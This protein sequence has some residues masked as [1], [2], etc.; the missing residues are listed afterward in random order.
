MGRDCGYTC[1]GGVG[2]LQT[3]RGSLEDSCLGNVLGVGPV[4]R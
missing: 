3:G 2:W 4:G 1:C